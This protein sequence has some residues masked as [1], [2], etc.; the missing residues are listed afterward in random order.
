MKIRRAGWTAAVL[1][2]MT[3]SVA[4]GQE[5]RIQVEVERG[6]GASTGQFYKASDLI[7]MEVRGENDA[8]LGEVQDLL[9]DS[10]SQEVEFLILDSGLLAGLGG[11]EMTV[12]PYVIA[13]TK[14]GTEADE[15]FLSVSLT[16]ER[17]KTAPK[18]NVS[19]AELMANAAWVTEV[20]Q[21]FEAE[22]QQHRVARPDLREDQ[23]GRERPNRERN[24]DRNRQGRPDQPEQPETPNQPTPERP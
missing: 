16:E 8:E 13:E 5:R 9:I 19:E 24:P 17:F 4:S 18:I 22:I 20:N 3:W 2:L 7:G 14:T 21:F 11:G 12:I 1:G 6:E 15:H 10:N 23:P